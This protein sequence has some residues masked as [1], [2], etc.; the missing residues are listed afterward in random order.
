[1]NREEPQT[2]GDYLLLARIGEGGMGVVHLARGRDGRRVALKVLRPH[3]VGDSEARERLAREVSSLRRISSPRIAEILDADPHGPTPFVVTRYVP[4]LSLYHHVEEEGRIEGADLLHC[5]DALA[6]ALQ[7][8][9]AVGVLHRDI[10]PTNV[11]MEGR[12]PVLIDFGLARVAE[13]SRLTQTGWLLGTPGYLAPEILY[14]DDAT[15]ASDVHAW[16]ATVV[17]AATGRPPYG[18]GPAMAIMDRVRRGEH[19]L[20]QVP[21]PLRTQLRQALAPDPLDRPSLHELRSWLRLEREDRHLARDA[22]RVA[23]QWTMPFAPQNAGGAGAGPVTASVPL[24][25]DHP[26]V[27]PVAVPPAAIEGDL[28][29]A[30]PSTR[31]LPRPM[32]GADRWEAPDI[33]PTPRPASRSQRVLQLL[34]VAA[35]TGAAVA[36]APYLGTALVAFVVLLLRTASVTRQR[37]ERRRLLRGRPRWYDVPT[38]TLSTPG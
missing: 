6:E 20:S 2:V 27:I 36:Y 31:I 1:M 38:T 8:V 26:P 16:A 21:E 33:A 9:H 19:D 34:G 17:F 3:V 15:T 14:G 30:A 23:D 7:A 18:R 32:D 25:T 12:S 10:K 35:V 37:H 29:L 11:L 4:G 24:E 5:A 13:D 28:P 22:A